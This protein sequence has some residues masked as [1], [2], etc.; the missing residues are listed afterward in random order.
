MP[1]AWNDAHTELHPFMREPKSPLKSSAC[2]RN[3]R[4]SFL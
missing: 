1:H 2:M 3:C 4:R